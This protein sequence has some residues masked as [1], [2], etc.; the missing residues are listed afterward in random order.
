M[1]TNN[2]TNNF[3]FNIGRHLTPTESFNCPTRQICMTT[4]RENIQPN[5]LSYNLNTCPGGLSI[6]QENVTNTSKTNAMS[7]QS[8]IVIGLNR[9]YFSRN[10]LVF[11]ILMVILCLLT[12]AYS[13]VELVLTSVFLNTVVIFILDIAISFIIAFDFTAKLI[14]AV[15]NTFNNRGR[16]IWKVIT[17]PSY[18]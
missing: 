16:N 17:I 15:C 3:N 4:V 5:L 9:L 7:N 12:C 11:Y 2:I 8:R 18:L 14:V 6:E 10:Y 1:A 13:V